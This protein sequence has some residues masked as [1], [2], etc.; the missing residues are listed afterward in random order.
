MWGQNALAVFL[1][2]QAIAFQELIHQVYFTSSHTGLIELVYTRSLFRGAI[3]TVYASPIV[4][5]WNDEF[6]RLWK[7]AV[8]I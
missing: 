6:E 2:L 5:C 4:R 7:E 1:S 3:S 8:V